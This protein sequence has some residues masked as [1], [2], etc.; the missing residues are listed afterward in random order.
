MKRSKID[1]I[2]KVVR[3]TVRTVLVLLIALSMIFIYGTIGALEH[4]LITF[5]QFFI[6]EA[7]L[8]VICY[9]CIRLYIFF[10]V[11]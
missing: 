2:R 11:D 7:V 4:S 6:Y 1:T 5:T 9:L 8:C 10:F 3:F